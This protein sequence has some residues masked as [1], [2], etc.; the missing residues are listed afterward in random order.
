M[1]ALRENAVVILALAAIVT[2]TL[3]IREYGAADEEQIRKETSTLGNRVNELDKIVAVR[4]VT[5]ESRLTQL[6]K[7]QEQLEKGQEQLEKGPSR[8][9]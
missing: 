1:K 8:T 7:G 3:A 6:E 5:V 2:L 9:G 4:L